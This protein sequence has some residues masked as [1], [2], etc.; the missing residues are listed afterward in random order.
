LMGKI[1][2]VKG[3]TSVVRIDSNWLK[4]SL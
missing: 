4:E 3:V 2:Q 1:K